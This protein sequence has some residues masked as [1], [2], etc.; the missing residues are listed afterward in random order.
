MGLDHRSTFGF[1]CS[2][3]RRVCDAWIGEVCIVA[4]LFWSSGLR[5]GVLGILKVFI[6]WLLWVGQAA[7]LKCLMWA[8]P[9]WYVWVVAM[10]HEFSFDCGIADTIYNASMPHTK[11]IPKLSS[12][13]LHPSNQPLQ[14]TSTPLLPTYRIIFSASD[15]ISPCSSKIKSELLHQYNLIR[16]LGRWEWRWVGFLKGARGDAWGFVGE[17]LHAASNIASTLD[18]GISGEW[19]SRIRWSW[20]TTHRCITAPIPNVPLFSSFL[21]SSP[22][23]SIITHEHSTFF[24]FKA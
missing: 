20:L 11:K 23:Q 18:P 16:G 5:N 6:S 22:T 1:L 19:R 13:P 21:F 12:P 9:E 14:T 4:C 7:S 8:G 24:L 17:N 3:R 10:K 2:A 15:S